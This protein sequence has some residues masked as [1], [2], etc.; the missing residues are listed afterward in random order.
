M[1]QDAVRA[2]HGPP[3]IPGVRE[4]GQV[5]TVTSIQSALSSAFRP[6]I[7]D[8][9]LSARVAGR[10]AGRRWFSTYCWMIDNGASP[11]DAAR[12]DG[13]HR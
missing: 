12:Y 10:H 9:I 13:D 3:G 4:D 8:P 2:P 1:T 5:N 6:G 11:Q 7:A